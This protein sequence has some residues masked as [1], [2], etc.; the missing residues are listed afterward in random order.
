MRWLGWSW[1]L[2]IFHVTWALLLRSHLKKV[3][4]LVSTNTKGILE[5]NFTMLTNKK[6]S[7][8]RF[9]STQLFRYYWVL[10]STTVYIRNYMS[11]MAV[12]TYL[13]GNLLVQSRL[14]KGGTRRRHRSTSYVQLFTYFLAFYVGIQPRCVNWCKAYAPLSSR[15]APLPPWHQL[16]PDRSHRRHRFNTYWT[17]RFIASTLK[18][19]PFVLRRETL[20]IFNG[21]YLLLVL[22]L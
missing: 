13:K 17:N 15:T 1:V 7:L 2:K 19:W 14:A 20:L 12:C 9:N 16:Y 4:H 18:W 8:N 10:L 5:F 11:D 6:I 21:S 22:H 3:V